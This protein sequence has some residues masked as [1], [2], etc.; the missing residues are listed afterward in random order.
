MFILVAIS[1]F[2]RLEAL[3]ICLLF[4]FSVKIENLVN[5]YFFARFPFHCQE[6]D[7]G[8]SDRKSGK[9]KTMCSVF[10]LAMARFFFVATHCLC[11]KRLPLPDFE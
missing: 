2:G 9:L 3:K 6:E 11:E 10:P 5:F 1:S 7:G 4:I 8:G